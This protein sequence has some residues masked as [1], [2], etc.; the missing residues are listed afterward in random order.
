MLPSSHP[1]SGGQQQPEEAEQ[2]TTDLSVCVLLAR[3]AGRPRSRAGPT[4]AQYVSSRACLTKS[5]LAKFLSC[6][7]RKTPHASHSLSLAVADFRK[8]KLDRSRLSVIS[9]HLAHPSWVFSPHSHPRLRSLAATASRPPH[10]PQE[11]AD[12][13]GRKEKKKNPPALPPRNKLPGTGAELCSPPSARRR[14]R[15]AAPFCSSPLLSSHDFQIS[16]ADHFSRI[17][18]GW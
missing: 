3:W 17:I 10:R 1:R 6:D 2:P 9:W 7:E 18:T 4:K 16:P 11:L 5:P 15:S 8:H 12:K 13:S 14:L